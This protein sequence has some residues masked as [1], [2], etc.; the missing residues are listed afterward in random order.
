MLLNYFNITQTW[1]INCRIKDTYAS[2][3]KVL[4]CLLNYLET[5]R[6]EIRCS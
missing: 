3:H 4:L 6:G 1:Y 2:I 5:V